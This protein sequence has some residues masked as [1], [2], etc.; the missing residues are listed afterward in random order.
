[1]RSGCSA[2]ADFPRARGE[3]QGPTV[4]SSYSLVVPGTRRSPALSRA[5]MVQ[6]VCWLH[7]PYHARSQHSGTAPAPTHTSQASN[8]RVR[9]NRCLA[10]LV[11]PESERACPKVQAVCFKS[12]L[13][14][15]GSSAW[16]R[17]RN[18]RNAPALEPGEVSGA[19]ETLRCILTKIR[20]SVIITP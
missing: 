6:E 7:T 10:P 13:C 11:S 3:C 20:T 2:L 17:I 16:K 15:S 1:M 5:G 4:L 19:E 18:A 12:P 9:G 8:A 14:C